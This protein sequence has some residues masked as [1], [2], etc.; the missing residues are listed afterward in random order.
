MRRQIDFLALAAPGVRRLKPYIPGKPPAELTRESGQTDVVKLASN[1]NPLG[2]PA[3]SVTA[4][5][6]A[7]ALVAQYPDGGAF[8]LKQRLATRLGVAP[9]CLTIGNGSNEILSLIAE[10]FLRPG[11]EAIYSEF[12]FLVYGLAVQA[13]NGVARVAPA[14]TSGAPQ[15]LGHDLDA[16]KALIGPRTRLIFIANPNNPTGTWV[17]P[18]QLEAFVAGVPDHVLV[19]LDEAYLEYMGDGD[20]PTTLPWLEACPNLIVCR[21]FSKMYGLA[22]LRVGYAVTHPDLAELLNRVRQPFNVNQLAQVAAVA[23]L[24]ASDHV[25]RSC[26]VNRQ[27]MTQLRDGLA[28]LGWSIAPSAGN[29]VLLECGGPADAWYAGLLRAGVIVRP[30]NNY[31]LPHHLRITVGL[32]EQNERLLRGLAELRQHGA[33]S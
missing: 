19:V 14:I 2:P 16:F 30:L 17:P 24:D 3:E 27:G 1:E 20:R 4:L 25:K 22:G 8:E 33:R 7:L 26:D 10:A 6:A 18:R 9:G 21:T 5:R 11:D 32:P 15:A 28:A 31:G 12:A 13:T 23:A 29:F